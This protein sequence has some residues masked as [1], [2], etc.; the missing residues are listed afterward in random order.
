[1]NVCP[2]PD[3]LSL[4]IGI[5]DGVRRG[6]CQSDVW[7][8]HRCL[9]GVACEG[10]REGLGWMHGCRRVTGVVVALKDLV[11]FYW[12]FEVEGAG[13]A[14]ERAMDAGW[15][16]VRV[17]INYSPEC[18]GIAV[19]MRRRCV[20]INCISECVDGVVMTCLSVFVCLLV[21]V[22]VGSVILKLSSPVRVIGK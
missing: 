6:L 21:V 11:R 3:G 18:G 12:M 2:L 8:F 1:M 5:G 17:I 20:I 15:R 4:A 13:C 7:P 19:G 10:N 14:G 22:V 9:L 16:S